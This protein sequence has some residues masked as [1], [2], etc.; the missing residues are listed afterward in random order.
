M[1]V[2][3]ASA[4]VYQVLSGRL[5]DS[6]TQ[7]RDLYTGCM[8]WWVGRSGMALSWVRAMQAWRVVRASRCC[9]VKPTCSQRG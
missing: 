3:A 2:T 1:A 4:A 7:V 5:P 8:A 6:S 9:P